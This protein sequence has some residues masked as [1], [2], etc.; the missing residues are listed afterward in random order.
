MESFE[1]LRE[2]LEEFVDVSP[3]RAIHEAT[4]DKN[5]RLYG[6][7]R[8]S[9]HDVFLSCVFV[10]YSGVKLNCVRGARQ[11]SD[12][13]STFHIYSLGCL[14]AMSQAVDQ[15]ESLRNN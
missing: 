15:G 8:F 10:G 5:D 1:F 12:F 13:V 4:V 14:F 6:R 9:S 7:I 11:Q 3:T 2:V